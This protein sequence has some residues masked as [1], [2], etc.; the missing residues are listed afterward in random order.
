MNVYRQLRKE[1]G[2]TQS[3]LA[4]S[5]GVTR[6][7]V[8]KIENFQYASPPPAVTYALVR[9]CRGAQ[10]ACSDGDLMA[11]FRYGVLEV[12]NR[13]KTLFNLTPGEMRRVTLTY[14][15][16]KTYRRFVHESQY[17]FSQL[18]AFDLSQL[19]AYEKEGAF[20][21]QLFDA[22]GD[23][24]SDENFEMLTH[25]IKLANRRGGLAGARI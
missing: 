19:Q 13:N 14:D 15:P 8:L 25:E 17:G 10:I 21:E 4:I 9:A 18:L 7:V 2:L 23:V 3:G 1:L 24:L 5:A 20:S 22:L 16:W 12:R 11:G 6:Q